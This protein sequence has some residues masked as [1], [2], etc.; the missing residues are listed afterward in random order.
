M[1]EE[2]QAAID[3]IMGCTPPDDPIAPSEPEEKRLALEQARGIAE[4]VQAG[5][6]SV[7][8][9]DLQAL[10]FACQIKT[11]AALTPALNAVQQ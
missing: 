4:A 9:E 5:T 8:I 2:E 1:T 3:I 7:N 11:M 10:A 6:L